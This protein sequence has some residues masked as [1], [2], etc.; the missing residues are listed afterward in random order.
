MSIN[1]DSWNNKNAFSTSRYWLGKLFLTL[2]DYQNNIVL[3]GK[4]WLDETYYPVVASDIELKED[5][6]KYRGLS[7]NQICIGAATDKENIVCFVEGTGKPSQRKTFDAFFNHIAPGSTLIHDREVTHK[8][9]I[10]KLDL[11]S[12]SHS[13][14]SL[15]KLSDSENPMN[16]VNKVHDS[17]KKFLDAHS[18]FSRDYLQ[19]YLNFY[20]FVRNPPHEPLEKIEHLVTLAFENPKS[21]RY[22]A[23]FYKDDDV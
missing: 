5:G 18:G 8:K 15:R 11:K 10:S 13:S 12:Q 21:L 17:L 16:P 22:R 23:Q 3:S 2:E 20:S 14:K 4:V 7:R 19:D 1:A 9:L 6:S